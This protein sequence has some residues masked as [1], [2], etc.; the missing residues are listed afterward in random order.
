MTHWVDENRE[1]MPP[2]PEPEMPEG[3]RY[4]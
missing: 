1:A 4:R 3:K 2:Q